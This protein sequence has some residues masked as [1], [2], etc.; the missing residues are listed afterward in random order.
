[1][2][3]SVSLTIGKKKLTTESR[4]QKSDVQINKINGVCP[5]KCGQAALLLNSTTLQYK[6]L[7][8]NVSS[9]GVRISESI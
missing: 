1:M 5:A 6:T 9:F 7:R 2:D 3:N 4:C 8:K